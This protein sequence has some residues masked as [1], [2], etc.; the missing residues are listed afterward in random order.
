ML[1]S[2]CLIA[3]QSFFSSFS[4]V[5]VDD[6]FLVSLKTFISVSLMVAPADLLYSDSKQEIKSPQRS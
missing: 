1:L 6:G 4:S 3:L 5:L 2:L